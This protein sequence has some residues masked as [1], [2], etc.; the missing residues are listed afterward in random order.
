ARAALL[1]RSIPT[2]EQ[3]ISATPRRQPHLAQTPSSPTNRISAAAA[4]EGTHHAIS[5]TLPPPQGEDQPIS[6]A[7]AA[8]R[9]AQEY[10]ETYNT[11]LTVFR[12]F[13]AA[14]EETARQFT[15]KPER[16]FAQNFATSFLDFWNQALTAP[17]PTYSSVAA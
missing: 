11:K 15:T 8:T 12:A 2:V 10:T 14:F 7:E 16:E 9:L 6:V 4:A 3:P 5:D 17:K 13:W 1:R